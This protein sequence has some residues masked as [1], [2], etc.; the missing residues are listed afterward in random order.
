MKEVANIYHHLGLY[1]QCAVQVH[2]QESVLNLKNFEFS[3][4]HVNGNV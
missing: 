1:V 2:E 3:I 4:F